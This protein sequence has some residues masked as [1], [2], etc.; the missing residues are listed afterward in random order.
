M[1]R[2]AALRASDADRDHVAERLRH[3]AA[4]GRILAEELEQR[5]ASA[6]RARTYGELH[7]LVSDLPR[8]QAAR[9]SR[10]STATVVVRSAL[11][12]AIVL[13]AIAVIAVTALFLAGMATLWLLCV[14]CLWAFRGRYASRPAI[15]R[16]G[17]WQVTRQADRRA[18]L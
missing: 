1:A 6:L 16:G 2:Y 11:G 17:Q 15:R 10:R 5:L 7:A 3:A 18:W 8:T 12:V 13:A 9:R 14:I 4:E